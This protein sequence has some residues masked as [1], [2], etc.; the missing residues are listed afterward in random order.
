MIF[1]RAGPPAD[2]PPDNRR[3]RG[4]S[5]AASRWS[6]PDAVRYMSVHSWKQPDSHGRSGTSWGRKQ[7]PARLGNPQAT[8]HFRR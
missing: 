5:G 6:G 8:G 1:S 3:N 7:R 2:G 4:T